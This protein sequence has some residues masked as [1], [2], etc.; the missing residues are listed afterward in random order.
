[1]Q[2]QPPPQC[3]IEN[4]GSMAVQVCP[5]PPQR[6]AQ[7]PRALPL[8]ARPMIAPAIPVIYTRGPPSPWLRIGYLTS[9]NKVK[10]MPLFHRQL[11]S[12]RSR[13]DYRAQDNNGVMLEIGE[14]VKW[15]DDGDIV[16]VEGYGT[17]TVR[18]YSEFR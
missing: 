13:Y 5:L 11:S 3:W 7:P 2:Q 6:I 8:L 9:D 16:H 1:M 4:R 17:Y 18:I 12:G 15:K 14:N 10:S